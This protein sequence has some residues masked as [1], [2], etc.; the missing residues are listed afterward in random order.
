M[1]VEQKGRTSAYFQEKIV[2]K[3]KDGSLSPHQW[4]RL[5][6]FSV[7]DRPPTDVDKVD[8][9]VVLGGIPYGPGFQKRMPLLEMYAD[10]Y[11]QAQIIFTG[12]GRDRRGNI[13]DKRPEAEI[14]AEHA[15]FQGID[16]SRFVI[17]PYSNNTKENVDAA[18]S[19]SLMSEGVL[20]ISSHLMGR[21]IDGYV[22]KNME[23]ICVFNPDFRYFIVDADVPKTPSTLTFE[24]V[25]F[26]K[27]RLKYEWARIPDYR[28]K[29]DL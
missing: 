6:R 19:M 21:R 4:L 9:I 27:E 11:P 29:G 20:F 28:D 3:L 13:E 18:I 15:E 25:E 8:T 5:E 10:I 23:N 1:V 24:E 7:F 16:A 17:E 2:T 26:R 12:D 14:M 22:L